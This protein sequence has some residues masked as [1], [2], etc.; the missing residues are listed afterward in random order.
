MKTL[1]NEKFA[2]DFASEWIAAWNARELDRI[3]RHYARDV[4]LASP[5]VSRILNNNENILRGNATLRVYFSR[6]LNAYPDLHFVLRRVYPG[7]QSLVIEY[8]SVK[9]LVAAEMMEVNEEGLVCR[10]RAHYAAIDMSA[11]K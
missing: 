8:E 1:F 11:K 2:V 10:A 7:A 5:F 3:L 6:A 4:E 9:N